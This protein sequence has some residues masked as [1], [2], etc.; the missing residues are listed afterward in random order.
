MSNIY[1]FP[2]KRKVKLSPQSFKLYNDYV[3]KI[4]CSSSAKEARLY[5]QMAMDIIQKALEKHK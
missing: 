4:R 1:P 3:A 2:P 5:Y